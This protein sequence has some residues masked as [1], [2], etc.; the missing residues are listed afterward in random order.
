MSKFGWQCYQDRCEGAYIEVSIVK[1]LNEKLDLAIEALDKISVG[2][3]PG[4]S[5]SRRIIAQET[6]AKL[7]GENAE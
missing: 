1:K 7:R 6:L 3:M 5:Y 2:S 4:G